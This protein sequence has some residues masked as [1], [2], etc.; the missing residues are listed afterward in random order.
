MFDVQQVV[1]YFSSGISSRCYTHCCTHKML[2]SLLRKSPFDVGHDSVPF[3]AE[4][5]LS[6]V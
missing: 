2:F 3:R 6:E 5:N 4:A 1:P